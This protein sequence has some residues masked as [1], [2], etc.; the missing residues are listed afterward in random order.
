MQAGDTRIEI[1]RGSAAAPVVAG[2]LPAAAPGAPAEGAAEAEPD[3]RHAIVAPLVG[4]FYRAPQPGAE[5][6]VEVGDTV[7]VGQSVGIVE[8]MKLMNQVLADEPGTVA[9]ILVE[10]G[11][12]G[13]V[14]AGAR[15]ARP[16]WRTS[17]CSRRC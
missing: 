12:V 14:R 16:R 10:N 7:D 1:E 15:P 13:R 11:A 6:F 3:N 4:T 9:E 8:A 5:P 2:A 17:R